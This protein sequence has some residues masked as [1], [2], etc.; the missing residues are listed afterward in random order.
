MVTCG[1]QSELSVNSYLN[2]VKFTVSVSVIEDTQGTSTSA[3][4]KEKRTL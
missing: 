1:N 2:T 4:L 3:V